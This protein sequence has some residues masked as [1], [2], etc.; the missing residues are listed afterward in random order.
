M[1][2]V[3]VLPQPAPGWTEGTCY[4]GCGYPI[5]PD[6]PDKVKPRMFYSRAHR[7][8]RAPD[9]RL[10]TEFNTK[11]CSTCEQRLPRDQFPTKTV[12]RKEGYVQRLSFY[13]HAC[14]RSHLVVMNQRSD[15]RE[16]SRIRAMEAYQNP[17]LRAR[18]LEANQRRYW[19]RKADPKQHEEMR[20]KAR[21]DRQKYLKRLKENPERWAKYLQAQADR[22]ARE[23]EV[24]HQRRIDKLDPLVI[25]PD[26]PMRDWLY[27]QVTKYADDRDMSLR[28]LFPDF[29]ITKWKKSTGHGARY[30]RF[31]MV[32]LI[33]VRLDLQHR[34]DDFQFVRRSELTGRVPKKVKRRG[35][36]GAVRSR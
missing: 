4:C 20:E 33:L 22:N 10:I 11:W 19:A 2:S 21:L 30:L 1:A 29:D 28:E 3:E 16:R 12:R 25:R 9:G 14:M 24:R 15:I 36:A 18:Q 5:P 8:T 23:R 35:R 32:D 27:E 13:C 7:S 17:H 31:E 26:D 6:R 34:L